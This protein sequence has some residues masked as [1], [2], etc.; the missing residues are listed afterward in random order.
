MLGMAE[1]AYNHS[2]PASTKISPFYAN[3][4]FEPRTTWPTEIQFRNPA[5]QLYG[6]Y[7][8]AVHNNLRERLTELIKAMRKHY[9]KKRR[10]IEPLKKGELVMLNR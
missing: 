10:S 6:H 2:K 9:D 7:M 3:Y 5:S 1:Y 8:G 4:R